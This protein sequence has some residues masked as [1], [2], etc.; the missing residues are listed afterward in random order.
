MNAFRWLT[1]VAVLSQACRSAPVGPGGAPP[2]AG[3]LQPP[4]PRSAL[5]RFPGDPLALACAA[6]GND[7]TVFRVRIIL[8]SIETAP[9]GV[10][11]I[12]LRPRSGDPTYTNVTAEL[13]FG[14]AGR[15]QGTACP[16]STGIVF[17]AVAVRL[18]GATVYLD[19]PSGAEV[20]ITNPGGTLLA[21]VTR[22]GP[23]PGEVTLGWG[24]RRGTT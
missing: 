17:R 6:P 19:P 9:G 4:E 11:S 5:F 21:P 23:Q 16:A 8:D 2:V 18:L 7:T 20:W 24:T 1:T 13:Q 3:E 12:V 10:L 15:L 14:P 22:S